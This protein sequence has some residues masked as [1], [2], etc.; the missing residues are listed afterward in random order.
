MCRAKLIAVLMAMAAPFAGG[1]SVMMAASSTSD[2]TQVL[3]AGVTSE[4]VQKKLGKPMCSDPGPE[5]GWRTDR[6][7][8][9][10]SDQAGPVRAGI[11]AVLDVA[12]LGLWE[13]V[14]MPF[15][16]ATNVDAH[17]STA[18]VVYDSQDRVV[19]W[20]IEERRPSGGAPSAADGQPGAEAPAAG[21]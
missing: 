8:C 6:Y 21:P 16:A 2:P 10:R 7:L 4:D 9:R 3:A 17:N 14:G 1:C 5:E 12:S 13:V 19:S 11:H 15:E 20:R 18:I